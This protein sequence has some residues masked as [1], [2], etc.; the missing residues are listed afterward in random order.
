M[1]LL[2]DIAR[3]LLGMFLA[4]AKLSGA[5]LVLVA[6]VAYLV[7]GSEWITPFAGG[8]ALLVGCLVILVGVAAAEARSNSK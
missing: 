1:T 6:T 4:D 5:I 8:A 7:D 2:G 3:E